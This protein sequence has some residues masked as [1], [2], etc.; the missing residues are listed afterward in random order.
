M[1]CGYMSYGTRISNNI[2]HFWI[3]PTSSP[4]FLKL[5]VV[6]TNIIND[7]TVSNDFDNI[8]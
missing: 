2:Y 8:G 1:V 5:V 3:F 4:P 7:V 6:N